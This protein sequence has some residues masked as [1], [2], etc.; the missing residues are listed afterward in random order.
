[1]HK[2]AIIGAG[3]VG[4]SIAYAAVLKH[5][6]S[7]ILLVD[8]DTPRC[9]AQVLD[10]A[11]AAF[12]AETTIRMGTFK[13][14]GQSDVIVITAGAKQRP[15]ETRV[16]LIDRNIQILRSCIDSMQPINPNAV[17]LLVSNPVD[18]LTQFAQRISGLPAS[19]VLGSGTYLDSARLRAA[20]ADHL[21]VAATAVHAYVLGEHGDSQ[22]VA[23]S[24]AHVGNTPLLQMPAMKGMNLNQMAA[25]VKNKAYKIIEAKGATHY[26]IGGCAASICESVLKN[27]LQVRPVSHFIPELGV[28]ISL[29]AVIGS[30]GVVSTLPPPLNEEETAKLKASAA[31]MKAVVDQY[32]SSV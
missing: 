13:E 2:L 9:E 25:D 21:H 15:G 12:L 28:C 20:L 27:T 6:A 1:M 32:A 3:S 14:A 4:S 23:W 19:Q 16:A 10:I 5:T 8:V 31:S 24:S 30:K 29:P 26:G 17:L 11:D 7:Q 18:V 22:F